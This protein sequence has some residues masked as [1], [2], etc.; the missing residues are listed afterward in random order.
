MNER[1][2][3]NLLHHIRPIHL[4]TTAGLFLL[5]T[6]LAR[7]LGERVDIAKFSSGLFWILWVQLGFFFLSDHF[8]TP[9]DIG[10][11][12]RLPPE[13]PKSQDKGDK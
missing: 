2:K 5:G 3:L 11:Y 12:N 13:T 6:G 10:L 8:E 9:F 7:Y 4:L 1:R